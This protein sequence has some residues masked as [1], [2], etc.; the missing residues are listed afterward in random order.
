MIPEMELDQ[1]LTSIQN[2]VKR[3]DI[4]ALREMSNKLIERAAITEDKNLVNLS[5][6]CYALS[7]LM[8]KPHIAESKKWQTF[9]T[10]LNKDLEKEIEKP[11]EKTDIS[12]LLK[13]VLDD[14]ATFDK[15]MGNYMMDIV[16]NARIKQGSRLY[17]LGLSMG[18]AAQMTGTSKPA[19]Q[20]Y[21][22]STKIHERHFTSSK[23]VKDR[24]RNAKEAL[25]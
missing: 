17:A 19:I 5:L 3:E 12:Q 1:Y 4:V 8:K 11:I 15:T 24:Y 16:D 20:S 21:I 22:G 6:I 2:L 23:T 25:E 18:Q 10:E 14:L 7:K 13:E 9:K